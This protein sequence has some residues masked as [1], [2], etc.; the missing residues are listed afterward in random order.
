MS[1]VKKKVNKKHTKKKVNKKVKHT[2]PKT[3]PKTTYKDKYVTILCG[4]FELQFRPNGG[5]VLTKGA[6]RARLFMKIPWILPVVPAK[7]P[8]LTA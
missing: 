8:S 6:L 5:K 1:I 7:K 2:K 3:K 4:D